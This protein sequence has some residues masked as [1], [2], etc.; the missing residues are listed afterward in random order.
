MALSKRRV[1][2]NN[3][4]ETGDSGSVASHEDPFFKFGYYLL[5][6]HNQSVFLKFSNIV[7]DFAAK[8]K[9]LCFE[10][11]EV[12][13][14]SQAY[15]EKVRQLKIEFETNLDNINLFQIPEYTIIRDYFA[16]VRPEDF[17]INPET[18]KFFC[19]IYEDWR[20]RMKKW[21]PYHNR[22]YEK[23]FAKM[24]E[25]ESG[26]VVGYIA[27]IFK[28]A[29]ENGMSR[30]EESSPLLEDQ[31]KKRSTRSQ[32]NLSNH[33][34]QNA[35]VTVLCSV[36]VAV[37]GK[38]PIILPLFVSLDYYQVNW[39]YQVPLCLTGMYFLRNVETI[40]DKQVN[41]AIVSDSSKERSKA[42]IIVATATILTFC[43]QMYLSSFNKKK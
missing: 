43:T 7:K 19:W 21:E 13:Q 9:E 24:D 5:E 10:K 37:F 22:I 28:P 35:D 38:Y 15:F 34:N 8:L 30:Q 20:I 14:S 39:Y 4:S 11:N 18:G 31:K 2:S 3:S 25:Q 1:Y 36:V 27:G 42:R 6:H 29:I 32:N 23:H 26:G 12:Q 33:Q 17:N 16:K 41:T 40:Y